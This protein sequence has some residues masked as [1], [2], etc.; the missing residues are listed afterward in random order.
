M[1]A[2][3]LTE[4]SSHGKLHSKALFKSADYN[5]HWAGKNHKARYFGKSLWYEPEWIHLSLYWFR[6]QPHCRFYPLGGY[7]RLIQEE[8]SSRFCWRD[9]IFVGRNQSRSWKWECAHAARALPF[10]FGRKREQKGPFLHGTSAA[11]RLSP[12][13]T[14]SANLKIR[15]YPCR[16]RQR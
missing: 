16:A 14:R 3:F 7:P 10:P 1:I 6:R 11:G 9:F 8:K 2:E 12:E 13:R 4:V 5:P 15:F